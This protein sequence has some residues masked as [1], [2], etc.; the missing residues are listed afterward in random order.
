MLTKVKPDTFV[1]HAAPLNYSLDE[2]EEK[3]ER[4]EEAEEYA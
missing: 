4:T 3:P 1:S 2:E